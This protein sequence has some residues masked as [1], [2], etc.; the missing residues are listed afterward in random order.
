RVTSGSRKIVNR[1]GTSLSVSHRN[2]T[3]R[4]GSVGRA[5]PK[6]TDRLVMNE[7]SH[8][9]TPLSYFRK[10]LRDARCLA[11]VVF[12]NR[13]VFMLLTRKGVEE[14]T[15]SFQSILIIAGFV[16]FDPLD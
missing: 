1:A 9:L 3:R 11:F 8:P 4:A 13:C 12:L 15:M 7:R 14:H 2:R 6:L 5:V 16:L 10:V